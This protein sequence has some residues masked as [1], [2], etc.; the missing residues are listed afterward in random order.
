MTAAPLRI[1]IIGD[2]KMGRAVAALAAER[3]CEVVAQFGAAGD[4]S[5][6]PLDAS[7]LAGAQVAIEF[8]V[9]DA[10]PANALACLAAGVP[11]VVGTTGWAA[12]R[13]QVE[14]AAR[15]AGGAL[16]HA[17]NFSP[18]VVLFTA[19]VEDAA[20]RFAAMPEVDAHLIDIH[21]RAKLDAPSGTGL[22]LAAAAARGLGRDVPVTSVRTGAVPGTHEL[23]LDAP[24]E[25]VRLVHEARDRRVFADGALAA[26]R[27][28]VGRRG[29]FSMRHVL[30]LDPVN[31]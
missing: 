21:H 24:F 6:R 29:V 7:S 16:L 5:G 9:P 17:P 22:A 30:G 27:W 11:V 3:G 28:L 31:E 26:A 14:A 23:I 15:A 8:T 2:G 4:A 12:A 20:R 18:G 13:E 10:A 19:L 25:Q 1:A